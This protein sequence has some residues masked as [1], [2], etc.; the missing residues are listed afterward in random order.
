MH[1][2]VASF[3]LIAVLGRSVTFTLQNIRTHDRE[4]F[5][6]WWPGMEK[7]MRKD[8]LFRLMNYL[9]NAYLK[10][11][12]W[13]WGSSGLRRRAGVA[14]CTGPEF[15]FPVHSQKAEEG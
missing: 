4:R 12:E 8:P 13:A 10:E 7:A 1:E 3:Y 2:A 5:N 9:R 15:S 14:S 11:V 6:A